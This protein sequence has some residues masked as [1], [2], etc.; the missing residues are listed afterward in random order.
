MV[1]GEHPKVT[2]DRQTRWGIA[3][4]ADRVRDLA[5]VCEPWV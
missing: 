3:Y 2:A 1:S 5:A 4:P